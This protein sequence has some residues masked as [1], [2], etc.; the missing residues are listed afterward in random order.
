MIVTDVFKNTTGHDIVNFFQGFIDF[1]NKYYDNYLGY[2][3]GL[4]PLN[5]YGAELISSLKIESLVIEDLFELNKDSLSHTIDSFTLYEDFLDIKLKIET[6]INSPKWTRS[7]YVNDFDRNINTTH[8][9]NFGQSLEDLSFNLGYNNPDDDWAKLAVDNGLSEIDYDLSGGNNLK[10]S[11]NVNTL[12]NTTSVVD[13]MTDDN[14]LGKDLPIK[15]RILNDDLTALTP[16]ATLSQAAGILL[17]LIRGSVPEFPNDGIGSEII[18]SNIKTLRH[19]IIFR[20]IA[21]VFRKDDTF[22]ELEVIN[23]I[24]NQDS[25]DMQIRIVSKLNDVLN[26]NIFING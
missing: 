21:D 23:A 15:I 18:G 1:T 5:R 25:M 6:I 20:Q 16:K 2:Y 12:I 3:K 9:L 7:S 4:S 8:I 10:A 17:G 19:P 26:K 14:V 22:K 11:F 13:I 24:N